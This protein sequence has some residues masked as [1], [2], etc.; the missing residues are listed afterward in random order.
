MITKQ[1]AA[2]LR[3]LVIIHHGRLGPDRSPLKEQISAAQL[4][5]TLADIEKL[6]EK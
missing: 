1:D 3:Q 2:K 4:E 5:L 6:T